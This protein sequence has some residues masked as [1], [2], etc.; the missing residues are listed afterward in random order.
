MKRK[1]FLKLS[2]AVP[3]VLA[4]AMGLSASAQEATQTETQAEAQTEEKERSSIMIDTIVVTSERVSFTEQ[5]VPTSLITFD[6][7]DLTELDAG[8]FKDLS[9]FM[10]NLSIGG[11]TPFGESVPLYSIRG[12]STA[13]GRVSAEPGVA[14]YIDGLYYPRTMGSLLKLVDVESVE[15]SRGPQ[16]TLF[17]RN[18]TAGT[19][20]YNTKAPE[21]EFGARVAGAV[22]T[23]NR[24]D[25]T[26]MINIPMGDR[27][28]LRVNAGTWNRDG[29]INVT[30]RDGNVIH[31][32]GNTDETA[33]RAALR[34]EPTDKLTI[35]LSG[36][37]AESNGLS[38]TPIISD[39]SVRQGEGGINA[40]NPGDPIPI[41]DDSL[42]PALRGLQAYL[43]NNGLD[44]LVAQDPRFISG[45]NYTRSFPCY[46]DQ[47]TPVEGDYIPADQLCKLEDS[48]KNTAYSLKVG[49]DFNDTWSIN[50][51]GGMIKGE[52]YTQNVL[53]GNLYNRVN[54]TEVDSESHEFTLNYTGDKLKAL[55]GVYFFKEQPFEH[56]G[57]R[58]HLIFGAPFQQGNVEA[59][60]EFVDAQV[61]T[62]AIFAN[63]VYDFS[64]KFSVT[65]GAR[66]SEDDKSTVIGFYDVVNGGADEVPIAEDYPG[67][68]IDWDGDG[69]VVAGVDGF[70]GQAYTNNGFDAFTGSAKFDS[71]DWRVSARYFVDPV[72]MVYGTV[73]TGFKGGGFS[74][75]LVTHVP[76]PSCGPGPLASGCVAYDT[77]VRPY[78]QE[79]VINYEVGIK[80]DWLD[81]RLRTN[82]SI[83][84]MDIKDHIV[85]FATFYQPRFGSPSLVMTN[86]GDVVISG[87]EADG[88]FI[89]SENWSVSGSVGHTKYDWS[90]LDPESELYYFD[91]C[92]DIAFEDV[93]VDNCPIRDSKL[94]PE[95]SFS[96]GANFNRDMLGGVVKA[97]L[98]YGWTDETEASN[99]DNSVRIDAYGVTNFR[100]EY[101]SD[102]EANWS[103]ALAGSN[104]LDEE[105]I[106]SGLE[107]S[108]QSPTY[109][110]TF[111][112]SR[113]AE[114]SLTLEKR[115]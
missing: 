37:V 102:D 98:N 92:P 32:S 109:T 81:S 33:F 30:D 49:Y 93:N 90:K 44:P 7:G 71:F 69:V 78:N 80:A 77:P 28:A 20:Q 111:V 12:V 86:A 22:G 15:I 51:L 36:T 54:V 35:D 96:A 48:I 76:E 25:L 113:G 68:T 18:S 57:D 112:P 40:I 83:Y 45:D 31:D 67:A 62:Q 114:W 88:E 3:S 47:A 29:Y 27:A 10:P 64:E 2:A 115:F 85:Q 8:N 43:Q 9:N 97:A 23:S 59:A 72:K 75:N 94:A 5:E 52:Y 11:A 17:G 89:L 103:I 79:D 46:L 16:G 55:G 24:A 21:Y 19:I 84:A 63:M 58:A 108:G 99:G 66:C 74:D 60:E 100:I 110:S 61:E 6:A 42:S 104:I 87:F 70:S 91:Q 101:D 65:V 56:T 106:L 1:Q 50:Y 39:F 82:A 34:L 107:L 38:P 4:L 13:S 14:V 41:N 95:W 53:F 105:Y 73:S 26:G